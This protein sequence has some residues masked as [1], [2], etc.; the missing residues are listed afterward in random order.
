MDRI[1]TG[2][3]F[4][5]CHLSHRTLSTPAAQYALVFLPGLI[6]GRL[7]DLGHF[8][9]PFLFGSIL[10]VISSV[11]T[12]EC[13][14]YWHFLLCQGILT[15]VRQFIRQTR[16]AHFVLSS[17]RLEAEFASGL[18]WELSVIGF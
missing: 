8:R 3:S 11:I 13:K 16:V 2:T 6:A 12:A 14:K 5:F 10:V 9:L 1:N 17:C 18:L 7:L 15:G 4:E